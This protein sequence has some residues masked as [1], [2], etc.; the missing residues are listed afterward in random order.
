MKIHSITIREYEKINSSVTRF[1]NFNI[2]LRRRKS[3]KH[4]RSRRRMSEANKLPILL[5]L[6]SIWFPSI[7]FLCLLLLPQCMT[8]G[9]YPYPQDIANTSRQIT[10][11]S[12]KNKEA[13]YL[14]YWNG[15][16]I[17]IILEFSS[18]TNKFSF[19]R[20]RK[21]IWNARKNNHKLSIAPSVTIKLTVPAA[22]KIRT[23]SKP[24]N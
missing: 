22:A 5:L 21:K 9:P 4:R 6:S 19:F 10:L 3:K 23:H 15:M 20:N 8:Q 1:I 16:G 7:H 14:L 2:R 12:N 11:R 17:R 13:C 24:Q 18:L